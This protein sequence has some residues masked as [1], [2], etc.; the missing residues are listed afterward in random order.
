MHTQ[1]KHKISSDFLLSPFSHIDDFKVD[2]WSLGIT[3]I[4]L[5][6]GRPPHFQVNPMRAIFMISS[7]PAPVIKN[8]EIWSSAMVNFLEY[9]LQKDASKRSSALQ[10]LSHP[11]I[12]DVIAEIDRLGSHSMQGLPVLQELAATVKPCLEEKRKL[13]KTASFGR[14][15]TVFENDQPHTDKMKCSPLVASGEHMLGSSYVESIGSDDTWSSQLFLSK[16]TAGKGMN[17]TL[18]EGRSFISEG[19]IATPI[20]GIAQQDTNSS[21]Q[22]TPSYGRHFSAGSDIHMNSPVSQPMPMSPRVPERNIPESPSARSVDGMNDSLVSRYCSPQAR[23]SLMGTNS[24]IDLELAGIARCNRAHEV[25]TG[26]RSADNKVRPLE[27]TEAKSWMGD[28]SGLDKLLE[29]CVHNDV[30]LY[31]EH[32]ASTPVVTSGESIGEFKPRDIMALSDA[33]N[34]QQE[35]FGQLPVSSLNSTSTSTSSYVST[36]GRSF[37]MLEA[38]EGVTAKDVNENSEFTTSVSPRGI[39]RQME[40]NSMERLEQVKLNMAAA[41]KSFRDV[42]AEPSSSSILSSDSSPDYEPTTHT[43]SV[44][45]SAAQL[46]TSTHPKGQAGDSPVL[47]PLLVPRQQLIS[48]LPSDEGGPV[49][50]TGNAVSASIDDPPLPSSS[51]SG[52]HK[53]GK[54]A[55]ASSLSGLPPLNMSKQQNL[56]SRIPSPLFQTPPISWSSTC[57]DSTSGTVP[58]SGRDAGETIIGTVD[59]SANAVDALQQLESLERQ[60]QLDMERL[61]KDFMGKRQELLSKAYNFVP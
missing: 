44:T 21:A 11:W 53:G 50:F 13:S 40:V 33:E 58:S 4:E 28:G 16:E 27:S 30:A 39:G 37:I 17:W 15:S 60:Y 35:F 49:L 3:I 25:V 56:D 51:S 19:E 8:P 23:S 32:A 7:K 29:E 18:Q 42:F 12:V 52:M 9:C 6:E 20:A 1:T 41:L 47:L 24:A 26:V 5:C 34:H 36:L 55:T 10:L 48:C 14:L 54:V 59:D 61:Q 38:S 45:V 43:T 2:I 57:G 22:L 46:S 31:G